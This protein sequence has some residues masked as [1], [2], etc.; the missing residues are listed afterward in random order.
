MA[1]LRDYHCPTHGYFE[2]FEAQCPMKACEEEVAIV[3]LQ[4]VGLKSD[5]TKH[6]DKTI[7]QLAMD[8]NMTDIKSTREGESQSGYLT[9]NNAPAPKEERPGDAAIWGN[10][11]GRWNVD[12]LV[13]GNG[14]RSVNGESVGVN[15]KDL[16]NL[17]APRTASYIADHE[18]LQISKNAD[19]K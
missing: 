4:P 11:G 16:G 2:S 5:K 9:R 12:S 13:K 19:T 15:P 10:A 6:N 14:Y 18:N 1:I 8:F 7:N 3:H 17:T